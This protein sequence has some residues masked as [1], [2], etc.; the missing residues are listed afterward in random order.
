MES[1]I[2]VTSSCPDESRVMIRN[3]R[4]STYFFIPVNYYFFCS[5]ELPN[6]QVCDATTDASSTKA[7]NIIPQKPPEWL[8]FWG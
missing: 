3:G 6:L 5:I 1:V 2:A 4:M 8:T 7:G